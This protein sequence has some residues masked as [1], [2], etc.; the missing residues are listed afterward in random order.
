MSAGVV[1][2]ARHRQQRRTAFVTTVL[3]VLAVALLTLAVSYG[4]FQISLPDI[5]RS[6]LGQPTPP[7]VDYIVHELRLPRALTGLLV[8]FALGLSGAIFQQLVRN[9]LAAPDVLGITAGAATFAVLG[10]TVLGLGGLVLSGVALGGALL[11]GVLIYTLSWRNGLGGYRMVLVGIGISAALAAC[12]SFLLATSDIKYAEQ[13]LLWLNGSLANRTWEQVVPVAII[14]VLLTPAV[15]LLGRTVTGL[16]LGDDL[17]RGLGLP[18]EAVRVVLLLL[19]V[20]LAGAGTA[21]AGPVSFVA[22]MSAPIAARLIGGGRPVL[23]PAALTGSVV[24]LLSDFAGQHLLGPHQ[25]PVGVVT[26]IIGT[27]YLLFLLATANRS[28]RGG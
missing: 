23:L 24:V 22:F 18:V 20:G 17:A 13:A 7:Q 5:V 15:L 16:Q 28:G 12:T 4:T 27:P 1:A 6:L 21:A 26:G 9:P 14:T 19:A 2:R 10:I 8:G 11:S 3:A 25:F